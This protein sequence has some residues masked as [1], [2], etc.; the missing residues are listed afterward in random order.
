MLLHEMEIFH[1]VVTQH[2]FSKAAEQLAVSK[3]YVSKH[4]TKLEQDLNVK[5]IVR[6][7]R[8]LSLTQA[9]QQFY[10]YCE[11][12]VRE[13]SAGYAMM[14]ELRGTPAGTLKVSVPPAVGMCLLAN[15]LPSFI[16]NNPQVKLNIELNNQLVDIIQGGY[17][18]V[19]RAAKLES[20][21]LIVQQVYTVQ[22]VI[23]ASPHYFKQQGVPAVPEDLAQHNVATYSFGRAA[24][25]VH[26]QHKAK[27]Y[28]INVQGNFTTNHLELIKEILLGDGGIAILP[29]YVVREEL[30]AGSLMTCLDEYQLKEQ[31][32]YAIYPQREFKL[33]KLQRFLELLLSL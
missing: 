30:A 19:V 4:M 28:E 26:M 32:L 6:S 22:S 18:L 2:S 24:Q 33:P 23:C 3:S 1:A 29:E 15:V 10:H 12:M 17:D 21:N 27:Q 14:D 5:L 25:H 8:K 9:G 31:P 11:H 13:A 20:S 7:T 16:S